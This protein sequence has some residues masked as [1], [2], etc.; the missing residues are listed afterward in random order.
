ME[1][2]NQMYNTS[3]MVLPHCPYFL[4][5]GEFRNNETMGH[6]AYFGDGEEAWNARRVRR[7]AKYGALT[8]SVLPSAY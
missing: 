2:L 5:T 4:V 1:I 6:E 8:A 7:E 3:A